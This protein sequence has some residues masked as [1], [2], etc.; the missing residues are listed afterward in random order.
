[1]KVS[2]LS[3]RAGVPLPTIKFYI[4]EGLLA[5][6]ARTARNQAIYDETHLERLALIRSLREEG[7]MS[8]GTISRV[9]RAMDGAADGNFVLAAID[10]VT[11][12][13]AAPVGDDGPGFRAGLALVRAATR[14]MG[15]NIEQSEHAAHDA[16]QALA[17]IARAFPQE[18]RKEVV[19]A[20]ARLAEEMAKM[21]IP[22]SWNPRA[23]PT[24]TLRYALLGTYLFEPLILALRRMAHTDRALKLAPMPA[25]PPRRRAGRTHRRRSP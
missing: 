21:E 25:A 24:A 9:L 6:G 17:A 7:G 10:A 18:T 13:P 2:E 20:Y 12:D 16:A 14:E 8:L 22:D 1:M 11:R 4:R 15:W 5:P 19:V 3:A 23:S